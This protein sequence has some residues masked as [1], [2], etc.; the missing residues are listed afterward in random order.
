MRY[1]GVF[2]SL[3]LV[4]SVAAG[5]VPAVAS[6]QSET[7]TLTVSVA[8]QD[9]AAVAGATLTATWENGSTTQTTA[10][11]GKAFVDV[12]GGANVSIDVSHPD[13]V[14][15][16]PYEI[17]DADERDVAIE[18]AEKASV[19]VS[20][21]DG[22]GLV[23]GAMV[24]LV[25]D[26]QTV[27][28][29]ETTDG[30]VSSGTIEAG[31]YS[32]TVTKA[33]YYATEKTLSIEND[34]TTTATI[35]RGTV[36]LVVN[37][38]DDYFETPRPVA[39]A[40]VDIETVGSVQTL[41]DGTQTVSVPVNSDLQVTVSKE[42]YDT[43]ERPLSVGESDVP[44]DV[45]LDRSANLSIEAMSDNVVVGEKVLVTVTDEYDDPVVDA[46]IRIGDATVAHTGE[47][48]TATVRIDAAGEHS[49]TATKN[50]TTSAAITVTGVATGES[51]TAATT[52]ETPTT[53][54]TTATETT[55]GTPIPDFPG[56]Y[57]P[58]L[59]VGVALI[60]VLLGIRA[61]QRG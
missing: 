35:E 4:G 19:T 57:V 36:P 5:G 33:G 15:N 42:G 47:D 39:G 37:V 34:S 32:L 22:E 43:V 49:I 7:V 52:T 61:W 31:T 1:L 3:L 50:D 40:T 58:M 51:T 60:A 23:D 6:A 54:A 11:N 25:K 28:E 53:E 55:Q 10:S 9:G 8:D 59:V 26:G 24:T 38:T 14:R 12:P 30:T 48:G 45:D 13:Y 2:L 20:V 44:L 29:G 56:Q 41:S 46:A 17:R 18:V 27:L 21:E 16:T